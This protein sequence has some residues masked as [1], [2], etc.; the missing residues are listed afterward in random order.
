V[1]YEIFVYLLNFFCLYCIF[2]PLRILFINIRA[3]AYGA[4][5]IVWLDIDLGNVTGLTN[6]SS[7]CPSDTENE[8]DVVIG[9]YMESPV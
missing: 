9:L 6:A 8:K 5:S 7:S 4:R 1:E 3:V 2:L